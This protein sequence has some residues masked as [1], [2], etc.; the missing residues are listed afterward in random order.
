MDDGVGFP[1]ISADGTTIVYRRLFDTHRLD[2][3]TK[4]AEPTRLRIV[5]T[6][7]PTVDAIERRTLSRATAAGFTDDAREIAFV[8]GGDL[9]VM[10]T[11]LREPVRLTN[12]PDE[13]SDPVFSPDHETLYFVSDAAGGP[14]IW[15]ARRSDAS[16]YWWQQESFRVERVTQDGATEEGLGFTP[17]GKLAYLKDGDLWV[18]NVED[19]DARRLVESFRGVGYSF[20]PDGAWVAYDKP[21]NDFN[22]DVWIRATDGKSDPVNISMHPDN[23][24]NPA[25]SPD[26]K[27]LAFAGRRWGT[28]SDICYVKLRKE[29][30]ER[31]SRDRKLEKAL[32]KMKGRKKPAAAG[33]EPGK[34]KAEKPSGAKPKPAAADPVTGR[35]QGS[36]KG[37]PPIPADGMDIT[38]KVTREGGALSGHVEIPSAFSGKLDTLTFEDGKIT[39]GMTTPLGQLKGEGSVSGDRMEG[40]W[41]I[42]GVMSGT[43]ELVREA[44]EEAKTAPKPTA[45]EPKKKPAQKAA[46]KKAKKPDPVEIDFEGIADRV[47]RIR[48]PDSR[49]YGL[50]WSPDSKKLAFSATV[51]GTRGLYSVTFPDNLSPKL[52]SSSV[53]TGG[54]WLEEG[55][56]IVWLSA[57]TPASLSASGKSTRYGF[58]VRQ[59]VNWPLVYGAAFDEAWRIMRDDFYDPA[60]GN[61]DW[62]A[63]R[64]K[65]RPLAAAA[66]TPDQLELAVNMMLGELNASHT[67]FRATQRRWSRSGWKDV[68]GHLGV[69]FDPT[70]EGTG[71]QIRDVIRGTP[72]W[73]ER[74][75]L[76]AGEVVLSIDGRPVRPST[77]LVPI[78]TGD[79]TREIELEVRATDGKTRT[80]RMRPTTYATVRRRLYD[81]WVEHRRKLVEEASGGRLGY[82]H[83]RGMN[84]PS[85]E[86]FEA[87]LYKV[88]HGKEGLILDVRN[89]GGGFTTDHLLTCLTQPAHAVTVPRGGGRGYPHDRMIYARWSKPIVVLCNQNSFS[90]AE[91]FAHAIRTLK[92]GRVVGVQTAGG[93]ISTGS[94]SVMGLG[95]IRVPGRGWFVLPTGQDMELNGCMPDIVVWPEPGDMPRGKDVQLDRAVEALLEDVATWKARPRPKLE[96]AAQRRKAAAK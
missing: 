24:G 14:D 83:I 94:A 15:S 78:M 68:T 61:R 77:D 64:A 66:V 71:L 49:E 88:G 81:H 28:E 82:L 6:G 51:K 54:R 50:L 75:R 5:Y 41:E 32:K 25:W 58:Q 96:T 46:K 73:Q 21:D 2:V 93:V 55:N 36:L 9:W 76:R 56:Q 34:A 79:P 33:K 16:K 38:L 80:V 22:W 17:D 57:G 18:M 69:R 87:E 35:W 52:M 23:D 65:Y 47:R 89:N 91:I 12:T 74:S 1:T 19:G 48:I 10:D 67:G 59:E 95:R 8:A 27:M 86:R 39:F 63:V 72:A 11:E 30:D 20:S 13:E 29:D 4:G 43:I 7:D 62:S 60:L 45:D 44:A 3:G 31:S 70:H 85:F 90:N 26:G 42:V 37:A 84:W 92:R 53:G 40:T